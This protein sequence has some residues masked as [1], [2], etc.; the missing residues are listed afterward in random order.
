MKITQAILDSLV[1]AG[2]GITSAEN[3]LGFAE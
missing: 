1:G 3:E 2:K